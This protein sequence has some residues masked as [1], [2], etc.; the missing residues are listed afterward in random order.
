MA[1]SFL[2]RVSYSLLLVSSL[3]TAPVPAAPIVSIQPAVKSVSVNDTFSV[4]VAIADVADLYGFQFE[5]SFSPT[6]LAVTNITEGAFLSSGGEAT[7]FIP[8]DIDNNA[9]TISLTADTLIGA[10][11]G[12]TGDGILASVSFQARGAGNSAIV[13]S[14]IKLLDSALN[15]ITS[16][17]TTNGTVEVSGGTTIPLPDTLLLFLGGWISLLL[18]RPR[19]SIGLDRE[20]GN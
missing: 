19:R 14:N 13:L 6:V 15:E 8:G 1:K 2:K 20:Q 3:A 16:F 10:I 7:F 17:T 11:S 9:G 5:L 12:V 4:D 18:S